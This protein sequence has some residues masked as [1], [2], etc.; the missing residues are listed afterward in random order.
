MNR[1]ATTV[2]DQIHPSVAPLFPAQA[3][4]Y[5]F[6]ADYYISWAWEAR[7]GEYAN[8]VTEEQF[9][10]FDERLAL[11]AKSATAGATIDPLDPQCPQLM[12]VVCMGRSYDR[13]VMEKWF[14]RAMLANPDN[15]KACN[16]KLT[17]LLPQWFGNNTDPLVFGRQCVEYGSAR[18]RI[19]VV[20]L[21]AHGLLANLAPDKDTYY[22]QPQ[23]WADI[24]SVYKKLLMDPER[25]KTDR[26]GWLFDRAKYVHYAYD[27]HQWQ[28]VIDLENQFRDDVD[29]TVFGSK[30]VYNFYKTKATQQLAK[31]PV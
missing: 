5:A 22:A 1:P 31:A 8:K 19:P 25:E 26:S 3:F 17:Y 15:S 7:G 28:A 4:P 29:I 10:L 23:V 13:T 27:C 11:A 6:A 14:S 2:F 20:L 9:K 21:T 24:D 12:I 16:A 30:A 18:S